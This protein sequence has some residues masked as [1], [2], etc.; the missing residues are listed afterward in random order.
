MRPKRAAF[1]SAGLLWQG[2]RPVDAVAL[3]IRA[4]PSHH[5]DGFL[6]V[7]PSGRAKTRNDNGQA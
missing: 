2:A 4:A 7:C 6:M 1:D 5:R 3:A